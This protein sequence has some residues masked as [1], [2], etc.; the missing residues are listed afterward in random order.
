MQDSGNNMSKL[1]MVMLLFLIIGISGAMAE[2]DFTGW[3]KVEVDESLINAS[4]TTV[5]TVMIPPG[6]IQNS[7]DSPVGPMTFVTNETDSTTTFNIYVM[8][9]PTGEMLTNETAKQFLDSFMEGAQITPLA[10]DPAIISDGLITYGTQGDNAVG[11]YLLST[12]EKVS[13]ITG[14]YK[15]MDEATAGIENLAMIAGTITITPDAS[16]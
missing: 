3:Q 11:I 9:N 13:I 2:I 8:D 16:T 15:N 14:F 4:S 6:M 1:P 10:G 12:D 7:T 5:Y